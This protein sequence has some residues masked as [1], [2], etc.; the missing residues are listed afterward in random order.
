MFLLDR[1][2]ENN[3]V[4]LLIFGVIF[5]LQFNFLSVFKV[6]NSFFIVLLGFLD[7]VFNNVIVFLGLDVKCFM[8]LELN[9]VSLVSLNIFGVRLFF[10]IMLVGIFR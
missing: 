1:L 6:V 9:L 10:V 2:V 8:Q 5:V 4:D 3:E 7:Y